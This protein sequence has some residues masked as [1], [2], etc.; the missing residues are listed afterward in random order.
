MHDPNLTCQV[1][2]GV[3]RIPP[4]GTPLCGGVP[5]YDTVMYITLS[6]RQLL[7]GPGAFR[8]SVLHGRTSRRSRQTRH[9]SSADLRT[10]STG[11]TSN[12]VRM[13]VSARFLMQS[14]PFVAVG[15]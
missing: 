14:R 4:G 1:R 11:A 2:H 6:R 13:I 7:F 5:T 12:S 9:V 8:S 10:L 3:R 15:R